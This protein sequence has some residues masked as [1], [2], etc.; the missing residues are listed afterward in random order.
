MYFL[1]VNLRIALD[2]ARYTIPKGLLSNPVRSDR[3]V[4]LEGFES[5]TALPMSTF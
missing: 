1:T 4:R 2:R 3:K 5:D